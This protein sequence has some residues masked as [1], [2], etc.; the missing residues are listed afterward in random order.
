MAVG[1]TA[2]A[3]A[4]STLPC[5]PMYLGVKAVLAKS[6][7]RI[8]QSNLVNVAILPLTF[9]DEAD[10]DRIDQ[11]D[12]LELADVRSQLTQGAELVIRN[13]TRGAEIPVRHALTPRQIEVY[14]AGGMLNYFGR[15]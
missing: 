10:Y 12:L 15:R 3:Q 4:A 6:F 9:A 13:L 11:G 7:A 2:R 1:T 5:C 8:H 14:R